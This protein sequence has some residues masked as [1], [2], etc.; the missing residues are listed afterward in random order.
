[1]S[2]KLD[3]LSI[4]IGFIA[5]L[6]FPRKSEMLKGSE[7]IHARGGHRPLGYV[8]CSR[9][10]VHPGASLVLHANLQRFGCE[11][12]DKGQDCHRRIRFP[13]LRRFRE[14]HEADSFTSIVAGRT[15]MIPGHLP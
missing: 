13:V 10:G 1:M 11:G 9:I 5:V 8:G 6:S 2:R 3:S 4:A 7:T 12:S 15:D 14:N